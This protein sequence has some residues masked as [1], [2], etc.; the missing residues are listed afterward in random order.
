M[1]LQNNESELVSN[2]FKEIN[3]YILG[4]CY[5]YPVLRDQIIKNGLLILKNQNLIFYF[6]SK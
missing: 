1:I 2:D 6:S 3:K 5:N 4:K